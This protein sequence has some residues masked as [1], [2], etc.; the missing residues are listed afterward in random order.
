M[1]RKRDW[2]FSSCF[3][4]DLWTLMKVTLNTILPPA[5]DTPAGDLD[6]SSV[7]EQPVLKADWPFCDDLT[8]PTWCP[9]HGAILSWLEATSDLEQNPSPLWG[10]LWLWS[11][12]YSFDALRMV[13]WPS[14]CK[15]DPYNLIW[16]L[17][18]TSRF[19]SSCL[20][21]TAAPLWI[22]PATRL[23]SN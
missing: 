12:S 2:W 16:P 10:A 5:K 14:L 6:S 7:C 21:A 4:V 15:S 11:V 23:F 8:H 1:I 22:P 17:L 13:S 9:G 3:F 19:L 18:Y 20:A